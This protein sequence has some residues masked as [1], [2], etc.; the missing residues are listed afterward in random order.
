M[1]LS[2]NSKRLLTALNLCSKAVNTNGVLATSCYRFHKTEQD[3]LQ[4]SACNMEISISSNVEC[5][6]IQM[7]DVLITA[8]DLAIIKTLPDQPLT[9]DFTEQH[10]QDELFY[11]VKMTHSSGNYKMQGY[12]GSDFP[13]IITKDAEPITLDF[14]DLYEAVSRTAYTRLTDTTENPLNGISV[15]LSATGIDIVAFNGVSFAKFNLTGSYDEAK[16]LLPNGIVLAVLGL[17]ISGE[18]SVSLS[19]SSITIE[20]VGCVLKSLLLSGKFIEWKPLLTIPDCWTLVNRMELI[21][22]IKRVLMFSDKFTNHIAL[23]IRENSLV[24][25]GED[26]NYAKVAD[27]TLLCSAAVPIQIGING[28]FAVETL[29][30]LTCDNVYLYYSHFTKPLLFRESKESVNMSLLAPVLIKENA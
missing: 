6:S 8:A 4:V 12:D 22:A 23:H 16:H 26:T 21:G 14:S 17:G 5:S 3:T 24:V 18:C 1:K 9:F 20:T 25:K 10:K 2:I 19:E 11:D 7:C 30:R 29:S 13:V 15:E 27:E 28:N